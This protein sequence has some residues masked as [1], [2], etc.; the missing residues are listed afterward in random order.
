MID[1]MNKNVFLNLAHSCRGIFRLSFFIF[2]V[3]GGDDVEKCA[4]NK[5][6]CCIFHD[7][8][9]CAECGLASSHFKR[10]HFA[11]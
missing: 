3:G 10:E 11:T 5:Q 1:G 9:E 8:G 4:L 7:Y 2:L 6:R